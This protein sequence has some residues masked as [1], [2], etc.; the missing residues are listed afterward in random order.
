M[1]LALVF[2]LLGAALVILPGALLVPKRRM[3]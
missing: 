3:D 1:Q 2:V